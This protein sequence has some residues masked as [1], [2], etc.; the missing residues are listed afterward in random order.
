MNGED[1]ILFLTTSSLLMN[2]YVQARCGTLRDWE[3]GN[4]RFH[5][6]LRAN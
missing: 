5:I 4:G 1:S 3:L 2:L 6:I